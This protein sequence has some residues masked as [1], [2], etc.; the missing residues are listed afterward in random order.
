MSKGAGQSHFSC[1]ECLSICNIYQKSALKTE[2]YTYEMSKH[3]KDKIKSVLIKIWSTEIKLPHL[4]SPVFE[5]VFSTNSIPCYISIILSM[6]EEFRLAAASKI[7]S[8]SYHYSQGLP[9]TNKMPF[10]N[11][12]YYI[13]VLSQDYISWRTTFI[14]LKS[15]KGEGL[16]SRASLEFPSPHSLTPMEI[17]FASDVL[18]NK[19]STNL[20]PTLNLTISHKLINSTHVCITS[21]VHRLFLLS[22]HR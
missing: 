4:L 13:K 16:V 17:L 10:P 20:T 1:N 15:W 2:Q 3:F 19:K 18:C 9:K 5:Y 7:P 22:Q 14:M 8:K 11:Y 21:H 12:I 6:L